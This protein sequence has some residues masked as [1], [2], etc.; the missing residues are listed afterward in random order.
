MCGGLRGAVGA[1]GGTAVAGLYGKAE[2]SIAV[3]DRVAL[4]TAV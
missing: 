1:G 4:D 3:R 2:W